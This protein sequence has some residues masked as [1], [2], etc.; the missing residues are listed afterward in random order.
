MIRHIVMFNLREVDSD[1]RERDV[2]EMRRRLTA[3]KGAI[4]GLRSTLLESDL[5][6]ID[7]HLDVVLITDH[8]DVAALGAYQAHERHRE[9]A[10]Y[11]RSLTTADRHT[12]DFEVVDR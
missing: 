6:I 8:D 10:E 12:V 4:P 11:I 9:L 3:L 5:N 1:S 7:G 2:T